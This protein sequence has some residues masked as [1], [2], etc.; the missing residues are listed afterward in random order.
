MSFNFK[1]KVDILP[2]PFLEKERKNYLI[3]LQL[4]TFN[5]R[6]ELRSINEERHE[7]SLGFHF[8]NLFYHFKFSLS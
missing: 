7:I 6:V 5:R 8:P 2:P 1:W 4:E 3:L